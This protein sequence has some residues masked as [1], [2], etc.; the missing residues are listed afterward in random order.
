MGRDLSILQFLFEQR[1]ATFQQLASRFFQSRDRSTVQH[2]LAKLIRSGY[3][4]AFGIPCLGRMRTAY[5]LEDKGFEVVKQ[6][7]RLKIAQS[8]YK[9][10]SV[11]H[12]IC[13]VDF[14]GRLERAKSIVQ[15]IPENVL[16]ACAAFTE[17]EK[18]RSFVAINADAALVVKTSN[19][20]FQVGFEFEASAKTPSRYEKKLSDYYLSSQV[21]AVFYVCSDARI[22][23]LI[24]HA[25]AEV[26]QKYEPKVYTCLQGTFQNGSFPLPFINRRNGKFMLS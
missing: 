2:R 1:V 3:I 17:S 9:S 10:D 11:L 20:Q 18:F 12:D 16:Q 4:V 22:E 13:L 19:R 14:R 6:T 7:Y 15:I 23:Q 26:G 24:R 21:A 25:D 8:L 5:A